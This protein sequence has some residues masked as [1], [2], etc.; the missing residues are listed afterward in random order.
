MQCGEVAHCRD[1][2]TF[3][4]VQEGIEGRS[5]RVAFFF[6]SEVHA[7]RHPAMICRSL[8]FLPLANTPTHP[9]SLTNTHTVYFS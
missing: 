9:L 8:P 5:V 4:R 2:Y 1:V 3:N 6:F 7:V